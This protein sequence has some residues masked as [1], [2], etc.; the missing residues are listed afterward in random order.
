MN[1]QN[2]IWGQ[3]FAFIKKKGELQ[4]AKLQRK[5]RALRYRTKIR[6]GIRVS[7]G[8]MLRMCPGKRHAWFHSEFGPIRKPIQ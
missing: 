7:K 1:R 5:L 4:S 2:F 6:E 8:A 3:L